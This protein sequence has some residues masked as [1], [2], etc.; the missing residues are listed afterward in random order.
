MG[1]LQGQQS[2]GTINSTKV[3]DYALLGHRTSWLMML[4]I[5]PKDE[6]ELVDLYNIFFP[7]FYSGVQTDIS[8]LNIFLLTSLKDTEK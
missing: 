2:F 7:F 8:Q 4:V 6:E 1:R 3:N 5:V